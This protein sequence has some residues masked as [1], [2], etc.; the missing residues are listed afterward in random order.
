MFLIVIVA[1]QYQEKNQDNNRQNKKYAMPSHQ[2][3]IKRKAKL[4]LKRFSKRLATDNESNSN[5]ST[6]IR[7]LSVDE[8]WDQLSSGVHDVFDQ[9]Y[10]DLAIE[11][12]D[13]VIHNLNEMFIKAIK[14]RLNVWIKMGNLTGQLKNAAILVEKAPTDPTGYISMARVYSMRGQQR[15]VIAVTSEGMRNVPSTEQP[16]SYKVLITLYQEAHARIAR[17]IDFLTELPYD[18][19]CTVADHLSKT[20]RGACVKVSR[21]WRDQL[22][23]YPKIWRTCTIYPVSY[24]LNLQLL[25]KITMFIKDLSIDCPSQS[26]FD[27]CMELVGTADFPILQK[28]AVSTRYWD[29]N[30]HDWVL[31]NVS[32]T[33]M[34]LDL[35]FHGTFAASLSR[36]LMICKKLTVL[37]YYCWTTSRWFSV[38]TLPGA[39]LLTNVDLGC[40]RGMVQGNRLIGLFENSPRLRVINMRSFDEGAL[41][42]IHQYCPD[43]TILTLNVDDYTDVVDV[44]ED[45]I[46]NDVVGLRHL[47]LYNVVSGAIVK[48]FLETHQNTIEELELVLYSEAELPTTAIVAGEGDD[49][50]FLSNL[51]NMPNIH[52]L[53][54]YAGRSSPIQEQN[55]L[56]AIRKC[57]ALY[58]L[59]LE[60]FSHHGITCD[61]FQAI[62]SLQELNKLRIASCH[63]ILPNGNNNNNNE[64]SDDTDETLNPTQLL[65]VLKNLTHVE[66]AYCRGS[67]DALLDGV[68]SI[69][70][71]MLVEIRGK[72][73]TM[74]VNLRNITSKLAILEFLQQIEFDSVNLSLEALQEFNEESCHI[75]QIV[76]RNIKN[77]DKYQ[78]R[79]I[80]PSH[81]S[82]I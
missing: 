60:C 82:I 16:E 26:I 18:I 41:P 29:N 2:D 80:L 4:P 36:I 17:R 6:S 81:I 12:S 24:D 61:T 66:I 54:I 35:A 63:I 33:L 45:R 68:A 30:C 7:C 34:E 51:N 55:L 46:P 5:D 65:G 11:Q 74:N 38:P 49:W 10:Y 9:G 57:P 69:P 59:S 42:A 3:S 67:T 72:M 47:L 58:F 19:A 64:D 31:T 27:K 20:A 25:P 15:G 71:L 76:L 40:H 53:S 8:M 79:Q 39:T 37:K 1:Q 50:G 56:S 75:K 62:G 14:L 78:A 22:L 77:I 32:D 28:L 70:N 52:R 44:V 23:H 13:E 73:T 43:L 21:A 48:P